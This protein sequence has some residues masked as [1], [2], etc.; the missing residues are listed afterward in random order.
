MLATLL[1]VGAVFVVAAGLRSWALAGIARARLRPGVVPARSAPRRVRIRRSRLV[2]GPPVQALA[3]LLDDVARRCA[4]GEALAHAFTA[5]REVATLS[6]LFDR[7][8]IALQRGATFAEALQQQSAET[9]GVALVVHILGLCAR[10]GGNVSEP[11]DRA[12]AT[13][14]ERHAASQERVAQSAQARLSARVLTLV[15]LGFASWTLLTSRDVQHFM[16]TPVGV[17]CVAL[18]LGLNL[19]GWRA[20]Q[21]IIG[22]LR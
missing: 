20:M 15:P 7:T 21:R 14:R 5:S 12:A 3:A 17:I 4:S 11:L 2:E 18:G 8:L 9:P 13:L 22:G 6:P 19:L 16:I 1:S 10:V